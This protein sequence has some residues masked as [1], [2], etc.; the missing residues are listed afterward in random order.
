MGFS[1]G[2]GS[3]DRVLCR[4][5]FRGGIGLRLPKRVLACRSSYR[6]HGIVGASTTPHALLGSVGNV[7]FERVGS[8]SEY[9]NSTNVCGVIRSSVS[10]RVLS[11]GVVRTGSTSTTMVIASGPNYL[12]RVGLKVRHRNLSKGMGT[13]RVTSVLLRTTIRGRAWEGYLYQGVAAC[14]APFL[15]RAGGARKEWALWSR[16]GKIRCGNGGRRWTFDS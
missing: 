8:T 2:L 7:R 4:L 6:L 16:W 5:R 10:V 11:R 14:R 3:V 12:L 1:R 9:Y 15:V 13:I